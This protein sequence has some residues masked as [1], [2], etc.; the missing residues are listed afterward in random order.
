[1]SRK[2]SKKQRTHTKHIHESNDAAE[3][4]PEKVDRQ[5]AHADTT[6]ARRRIALGKND[7][8]LEF[9]LDKILT[10]TEEYMDEE[11]C[12]D[13]Q[14]VLDIW[15]SEIV[16]GFEEYQERARENSA[17]TRNLKRLTKERKQLRQFILETKKELCA[18]QEAIRQEEELHRKT[19]SERMS[20]ETLHAFFDKF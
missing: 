18:T 17:L 10:V 2:T 13:I 16:A 9:V 20:K 12:S 5:V 3:S 19:E 7:Q 14:P 4:T 6:Q 8:V 11:D 1:V 15:K